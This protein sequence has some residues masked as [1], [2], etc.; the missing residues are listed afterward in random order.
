MKFN[1]EKYID[2]ITYILFKTC[3]KRNFGKTLLSTIMYFIDFDY[4]QL[5]GTFLTQE[6]Y[7]KSKKGIKPKHLQEITQELIS[8]N[9]LIMR[10]EP[11]YSRIIHRY[12]LT[13]IPA[14]KF[15][16]KEQEIIDLV[17]NNLSNNNAHTITQYA[18]NDPPLVIAEFGEIIDYKY[19]YSRPADYSQLRK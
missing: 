2:L 7:I 14:P 16:K 15:S 8:K 19:V 6:T 3:N 12:Y 13:I 4:Y 5:Y 17:I 11:Y 10:K 18:K 1:R 9:K